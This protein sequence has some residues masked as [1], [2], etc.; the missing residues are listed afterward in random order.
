MGFILFDIMEVCGLPMDGKKQNMIN[1]MDI[2]NKGDLSITNY[3]G[4]SYLSFRF[5]SIDR[6]D[7]VEEINMYNKCLQ[8]HNVNVRH[9]IRTDNCACNSGKAYKN[10][11]GQSVYAKYGNSLNALYDTPQKINNQRLDSFKTK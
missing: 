2:I 1:G 4:Q 9:H 6:I 7:Y 3:Q 8:K 5:P 11:H 10:C